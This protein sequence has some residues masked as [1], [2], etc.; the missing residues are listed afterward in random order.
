MLTNRDYQIGG[1][2]KL[3]EI[4]GNLRIKDKYSIAFDFAKS[5]TQESHQD[6]INSTDTLNNI[7]YAMDGEKF[8]RCKKYKIKRE[9]EGSTWGFRFEE[10]SPNYRA[11]VGF[12]TQTGFKNISLWHSR[13]YRS[14]NFFRLI[15]PNITV[16]KK[17]DFE[18][19][20]IREMTELGLF[21]ETSKNF[22]GNIERKIFK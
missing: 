13:T 21:F 1:N 4:D 20:T 5:N 17:S 10:I 22:K 6:F 19:N 15:K 2:G 16:R 14:N 3:V 7:S 8:R 18:G 9:T 12:V 11:D